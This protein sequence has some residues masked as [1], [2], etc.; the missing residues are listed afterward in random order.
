MRGG[1]LAAEGGEEVGESTVGY[2]WEDIM[3]EIDQERN[4]RAQAFHEIGQLRSGQK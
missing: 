2:K 3:G 1:G 4:W